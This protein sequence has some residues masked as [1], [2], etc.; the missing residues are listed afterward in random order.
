MLLKIRI[1]NF[2]FQ[3]LFLHECNVKIIGSYNCF[4]PFSAIK[5]PFSANHLEF[6]NE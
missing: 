2:S 6:S 4:M 1:K 3:L 5:E